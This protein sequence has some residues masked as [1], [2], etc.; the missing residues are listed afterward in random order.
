MMAVAVVVDVLPGLATGRPVAF[1][2]RDAGADAVEVRHP[3]V[4]LCV[5]V[6]DVGCKMGECV[7]GR[8]GGD[9][10]WPTGGQAGMRVGTSV[11]Y[12]CIL[13]YKPTNPE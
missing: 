11:P 12:T 8:V 3:V 6:H 2:M 7:G 10:G 9:S 1:S 4:Q 5:Y 13:E